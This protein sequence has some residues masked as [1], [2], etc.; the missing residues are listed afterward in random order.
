M[1]EGGWRGK[2]RAMSKKIFLMGMGLAMV[3]LIAWV[4]YLTGFAVSLSVFYLIPISMVVWYVGRAAGMAV[5][6]LSAIVWLLVELFS[7]LSLPT[8]FLPY[9]QAVMRLGFLLIVIFLM[10]GRQ[11]AEREREKL[12]V[13]L[14]EA[15][16]NVK[17]LR[18][19]LPIC[20]S[21]KKVRDDRGYWNQI[22]SFV[23]ERSEA[24]FSHSICPECEKKLY[25]E[26]G[27]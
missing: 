23:R 14:Q 17:T 7:D 24:A 12:I 5:A 20:S 2:Q 22:E 18:G 11:R 16:A 6:G 3:V 25:P 4:D 15:L 21:C 8:M 19:L 10:D 1:R 13:E 9:W 26:L 27:D